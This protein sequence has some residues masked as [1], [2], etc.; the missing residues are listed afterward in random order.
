MSISQ[1]ESRLRNA[2][3]LPGEVVK[4][5]YEIVDLLGRGTS[6]TVYKARDLIAGTTIALKLISATVRN[7]EAAAKRLHQEI[8]IAYS[9]KSDYVTNLYSCFT[10]KNHVGLVLEYVQG[11][12]L[13]ELN[14]EMQMLSLQEIFNIGRQVSLGLR[15]I[16][17]AG[18]V[19]RD[20]KLEN[21]LLDERGI[22]KITDF[23][24]SILESTVFEGHDLEDVELLYQESSRRR[25]T[26]EGKI[27]GTV[28]YLSPEYLRTQRCDARADIYA[29]GIVLYELVTM[30]Y[31]F[32][33]RNLKDLMR[34][35]MKESPVPPQELREEC[36]QWLND[37]I[38]KAMDRDPEKRY[39]S[40]EELYEEFA[41][42]MYRY[43]IEKSIESIRVSAGIQISSLSA[44]TTERWSIPRQALLAGSALLA[45]Y[46]FIVNFGFFE[47]LYHQLFPKELLTRMLAMIG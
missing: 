21:I 41:T 45:C 9:V 4:E 44:E 36:P 40:A 42:A 3:Y 16:H 14:E 33:Y 20:L 12:S 1:L 34:R 5:R 17:E 26:E 2:L 43:P 38:L 28:H 47:M 39:Q 29:L 6:G 19:H 46:L 35:K 13:Y 30:K 27:V 31:P 37:L 10:D 8:R 7:R 24:V 15:A 32:D 11:T 22:A 25:A 18:I 23:G